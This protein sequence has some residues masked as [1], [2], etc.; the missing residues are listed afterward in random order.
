MRIVTILKQDRVLGLIF[1]V[2]FFV[3]AVAAGLFYFRFFKISSPLVIHQDV[4]RGVDVLVPK[5]YFLKIIGVAFVV[6]L[7]NIFL[8]SHTFEKEKFLSYLLGIATVVVN[9]LVLIAAVVL[10]NGNL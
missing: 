3:L 10:I 7:I 6:Y 4:Y 1:G 8:A 2:G 9:M 5:S